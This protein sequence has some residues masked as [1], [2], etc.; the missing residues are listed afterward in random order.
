MTTYP[1]STTFPRQEFYDE[2]L[3]GCS[4]GLTKRELYAGLAL[5]GLLAN[6]PYSGNKVVAK[7]AVE[8]ADAL[9]EALNREEE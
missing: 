5:Q 3:V 9:I 6:Q 8:I 2:K 4:G 1:G 7:R